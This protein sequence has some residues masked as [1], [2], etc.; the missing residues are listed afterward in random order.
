VKA[1]RKYDTKL[2]AELAEEYNLTYTAFDEVQNDLKDKAKGK[3]TLTSPGGLDPA[4][5]TPLDGAPYNLLSGTIRAAYNS[6]RGLD[7]DAEDIYV[8]PGMP[9]GNTGKTL[10]DIYR[11]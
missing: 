5:V 2:L 1:T 7:K 4:P 11:V 6:H 3:L 8:S 9:T 10:H